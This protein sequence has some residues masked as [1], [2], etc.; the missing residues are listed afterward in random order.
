[1]KGRSD[2][3]Q[4]LRAKR[5]SR[6]HRAVTRVYD[7]AGDVIETREHKGDF[8]GWHRLG[9]PSRLLLF[10]KFLETRICAGRIEP[11]MEPEQRKLDQRE[12]GEIIWFASFSKRG[13][14]RNGSRFGSIL[15]AARGGSLAW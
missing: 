5:L 11:Q 10:A 4:L 15:I 14:P 1:M 6:S 9:G 3:A 7:E 12:S 8:R 2:C 13:S